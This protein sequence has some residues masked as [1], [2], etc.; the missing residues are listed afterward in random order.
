MNLLIKGA[1]GTQ[2]G[3]KMITGFVSARN[4]AEL[5]ENGGLKIDEYSISNPDGYQRE[6]SITRARKFARFI[7]DDENGISPTNI[8][9]YLRQN[10]EPVVKEGN[11]SLPD[12]APLYIVDGQHRT[13]GFSEAYKIGLLGESE[14][15]DVPISLLI[16]SPDKSPEDQ[17]LEEAMQF[18]TINTQLKRPRTDLAHQYIYKVKQVEKGPIGPNTKLPMDLKKKDYVPYEI[19]I[20]EQ[21][22]KSGPWKNLIIPPNG[23]DEAPMSQGSFTDSLGPVLDFAQ[24]AG[25]TMGNVIELINNYW[26]A[27][28]EL[29]PESYD[30][31][32]NYLLMKTSGVYSLHLFLPLLLTRKRNLGNLPTK[33]QFLKVLSTMNEHF[34]DSF[35][36]AQNG[37]ASK[38][39]GGKKAFTEIYRDIIDE[40]DQEE[41]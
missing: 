1:V 31:W 4:L 8:L 3:R 25:L 6:H 21:L 15:F 11:I 32:G 7:A 28:T 40:L 17:R 30:D 33:E 9:I 10:F 2:H 39:G 27:I 18:Y 35:W 23:H 14:N 36:N 29:C 12:G 22:Y 37:S 16:W 5:Y 24:N 41:R 13:V 26:S 20:S 19:Y 38:F 34:S